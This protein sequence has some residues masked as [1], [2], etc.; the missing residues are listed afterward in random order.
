[1]ALAVGSTDNQRVSSSLTNSKAFVNTAGNGMVIVV[2]SFDT[3]LLNR[4]VSLITYGVANATKIAGSVVDDAVNGIRAE[5]WYINSPPTGSNTLTITMGG[6]C[7]DIDAGWITFTGSD[8][9]SAF[10]NASN[11][12]A[13]VVSNSLAVQVTTTVDN[14]YLIAGIEGGGVITIDAT[15]TS[16]FNLAGGGN[17]GQYKSVGVAGPFTLTNTSSANPD[18]L[19]MTMIAIAPPSAAPPV[20]GFPTVRT[21]MG[22]GI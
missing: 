5:T 16:F 22:V 6:I 11:T 18:T 1:M 20:A 9:T 3:T 10:I 14:C 2:T 12:G 13:T 8:T 17:R 15:S 21:L 4:S 19:V 7:A